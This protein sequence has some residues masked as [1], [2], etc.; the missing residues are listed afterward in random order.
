MVPSLS[1]PLVQVPPLYRLPCPGGWPESPARCRAVSRAFSRS[2]AEGLCGRRR[3]CPTLRMLRRAPRLAASSKARAVIETRTPAVRPR[4]VYLK[5]RIVRPV[6][7]RRFVA[8]SLRLRHA[9]VDAVGVAGRCAP[10]DRVARSLA[11]P[12]KPCRP[13]LHGDLAGD[14]RWTCVRGAPRRWL[15]QPARAEKPSADRSLLEPPVVEDQ[16]VRPLAEAAQSLR[17]SLRCLCQRARVS[18]RH[19]SLP[20]SPRR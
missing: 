9:E 8:L 16:Q 18:A 6:E 1:Q 7:W 17:R 11:Q 2:A 3:Q 13:L 5:R 4:G 19:S 12:D 20:F 15:Q 10:E 14:E